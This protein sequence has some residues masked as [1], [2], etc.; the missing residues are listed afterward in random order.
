MTSQRAV[1]E[2][3][4][5]EVNC[6]VFSSL[7]KKF[8]CLGRLLMFSQG[9]F[10]VFEPRTH[11]CRVCSSSMAIRSSLISAC[12][13]SIVTSSLC[14]K[15]SPSTITLGAG[16]RTAGGVLGQAGLAVIGTK[17]STA[18]SESDSVQCQLRENANTSFPLE[19]LVVQLFI[20]SSSEAT[21][22]TNLWQIRCVGLLRRRFRLWLFNG[23]L[24]LE[25]GTTAFI[26]CHL[27]GFHCSF[28][29]K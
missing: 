24:G 28:F 17:W 27:P 5:K 21:C 3:K 14:T 23:T 12:S 9:C 8:S 7:K 20:F 10:F 22:V 26:M 25:N 29:A 11:S 6:H 18:C 15:T 2:Q 16:G 19:R 4:T 1:P 13:C